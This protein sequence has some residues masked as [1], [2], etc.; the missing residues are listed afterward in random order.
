MRHVVLAIICVVLELLHN[1]HN[2]RTISWN[3]SSLT[4]VTGQYLLLF[5]GIVL[6]L[7]K[8]YKLSLSWIKCLN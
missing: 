5:H 7:N 8:F 1:V 3:K 4:A 6:V 2:T